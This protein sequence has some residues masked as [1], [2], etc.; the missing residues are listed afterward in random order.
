MTPFD[1]DVAVIGGGPAG[2]TVAHLLAKRGRQVLVLEKE[3]FPRFHVG[4]SLLAHNLPILERLGVD[5]SGAF[6]RKG[7]AEFVHEPTGRHTAFPFADGLPGTGDHAYQVERSKF[8]KLL[9]DTAEAAGA[10][11]HQ[12]E[13][14]RSIEVESDC[15]AIE[16]SAA[17]YSTRYCIDA[18]G[19]DFFLGRRRRT[20]APIRGFGVIGMFKHFLGLRPEVVAELSATGNI[21]VFMISRG[22]MWAIPLAGNKVSVGIVSRERGVE[23]S[24]LDEEIAA[25]PM[26]CHI[27]GGA[28][29]STPSRL[30]RHFAAV[31]RKVYGARFACVGDA[32]AFLDPVFSSGVCLGMVGG[33]RLADVVGPALS[34]GYEGREDLC[35][36]WSADMRIGYERMGTLVHSFYNARI[37]EN[38]FFCTDPEPLMRAGLITMLT[39]D[40]WRDDNLFQDRLMAGRRRWSLDDADNAPG[41]PDAPEVTV[42]A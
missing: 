11:V 1:A 18:T 20:I 27:I 16:T 5:L 25:S 13:S 37:V 42:R 6:M 24:H 15:V 3:Q 10:D 40:L 30:I 7:G 39:G 4:E 9:L 12:N 38:L 32:A 19:Q 36:A 8:D 41:N 22:W 26:L 33:E 21:R 2:S 29:S 31:N 14:V 17:R 28:E 35:A 34:G 23:P